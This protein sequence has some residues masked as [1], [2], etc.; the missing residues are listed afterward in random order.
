MYLFQSLNVHS[1]EAIIEIGKQG[2]HC[3]SLTSGLKKCVRKKW[4]TKEGKIYMVGSQI[5]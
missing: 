1:R 3:I 5:G 4:N 2:Y